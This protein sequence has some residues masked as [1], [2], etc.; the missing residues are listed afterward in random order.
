[1]TF[2]FQGVTEVDSWK[3]WEWLYLQMKVQCT[4]QC[5]E[6]AK[7]TAFGPKKGHKW[8]PFKS[9][10][11]LQKS[12]FG[13]Q[14]QLQVCPSYMCCLQTKLREQCIT[15]RTFCLYFYLMVRIR[16]VILEKLQKEDLWKHVGFDIVSEWSTSSQGHRNS[17]SALKQFFSILNQRL[18]TPKHTWPVSHRISGWNFQSQGGN[19]K[20]LLQKSWISSDLINACREMISPET[21]ENLIKSIPYQ[22]KSVIKAKGYFPLK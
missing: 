4:C 22:I 7:M 8:N 20:T 11:L 16:P 15:K 21:L 6:L 9:P 13:A 19:V 17:K 3:T 14:W 12:W 2:V 5:L 10:T 1:M 18:M